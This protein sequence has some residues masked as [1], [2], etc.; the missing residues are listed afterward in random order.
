LLSRTPEVAL[1][2][3]PFDEFRTNIQETIIAVD[4]VIKELKEL[5]KR[6]HK[7]AK[8]NLSY[9]QGL[10]SIMN[11]EKHYRTSNYIDAI[12]EYVEGGKQ[13]ETFQRNNT[14]LTIAQQQ[15][16]ERLDSFTK[17]RQF[18]CQALKAGTA[19]DD[20]LTNLLEALNSYIL[21]IE[22]AN[23]MK[24]I[25]L[26]YNAEARKNFVQGLI[27]HLEG[28]KAT[29]DKNY[30][31]AKDK[32]LEAYGFF[33]KAAYYNPSYTLWVAEQNKIIK[34]TLYS[35]VKD[36]AEKNWEEA[37]S[38]TNNGSFIES[39]E[40]FL[41]AS[42]LY[43]RACMLA[44]EQKEALLM[45]AHSHLLRANMYE[46]KANDFIK[47]KNNAKDA[48]PQFEFAA[49]AMKKAIASYP[50]RDDETEFVEQWKTLMHFYIG[51]KHQS[52]G[53]VNLDQEQFKEALDFFTEA[54]K[55]FQI[56]MQAAEKSGEG[57]LI[58]LVDKAI[59][60]ANG[61]IGMCKTVLP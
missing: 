4:N 35:V 1:S 57:P 12:A 56:A 27:K 29:T 25:L 50:V 42:K 22:I 15:E 38:L 8:A 13:I 43:A 11:A 54:E 51:H 40:K 16:M 34:K 21:E 55:E 44:H 17:G 6:G 49:E 36:S 28:L 45:Q 23:T 7:I 5:E 14:D 33:T 39:S 19:L 18:E 58:S 26:N 52:K 59:A 46:A 47:M 31:L 10:Y 60:E 3:I 53:I 24:K 30:R 37:Q 9:Y 20:Q 32:H 41:I 61:Y 48:A 2:L